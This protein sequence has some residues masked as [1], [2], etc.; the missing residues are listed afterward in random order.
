M[1]SDQKVSDYCDSVLRAF[2]VDILPGRFGIRACKREIL[3]EEHGSQMAREL[4]NLNKN[5]LVLIA[6]G[7]YMRH[8][9]SSNNQYQRKSYSGQKKTHLCKPFTL[10]T[11]DG[12]IVDILGPYDANRNDATIMENLIESNEDLKSLLKNDDVLVLDR[13]F[14]DV[15]SKLEDKG[16][17]VLMPSLKGKKA[18]LSTSESNFSRL[19]TKIR[20]VV[21]GVH[22]VM[23]QKYKLL[24]HQ[25]SNAMLIN[26]GTYTRVAGFLTNE[27]GKRFLCDTDMLQEI[28]SR[29]KLPQPDDNTLAKQ[30]ETE[31]WNRKR[32]PFK[33]ID[34]IN[35]LDDF[36]ELTLKDLKLLFTGTYQLKMAVSYL[37]EMMENHKSIELQYLVQQREIIRVSVRSRH[38]NAKTYNVYVHYSANTVGCAGIRRYCCDCANGNRTIGCCS[39]VATVVYY[40]SYGRFLSK[41]FEPAR[42]LSD[43]FSFDEITPVIEENSDDDD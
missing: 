2:K 24:H 21:E 6:D 27:F 3:L 17:K 18:Q 20:W 43:L 19:V 42:I 4:H 13:G 34:A 23:G 15:V 28:I 12:F 25:F 10:C 37:A 14:R 1:K 30:V 33:A 11:P 26:A 22:G 41:E 29:M 39:H 5:Q 38:K 36:P 8:Q 16:F 7:T 31:N 32:T 9:K 35:D 40:L